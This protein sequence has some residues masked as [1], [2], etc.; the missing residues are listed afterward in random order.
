MSAVGLLCRQYLG[1]PRRNPNL[2]NGVKKL[3]EYAPPANAPNIYFEYYATQVFHHMSG[4]YW[5]FWNGDE[6][7]K[8]RGMRDILIE[9]Q[10]KD[11]SWI[12]RATLTVRSVGELCR[13]R[14]LC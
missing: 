2:R 4:E 11:G 3:M 5:D 7:T 13:R 1:T 10:E 12:R 9:R 8:R 14:S 6:A